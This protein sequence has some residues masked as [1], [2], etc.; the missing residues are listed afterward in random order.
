[1]ELTFKDFKE[2]IWI[3]VD[4]HKNFWTQSTPIYKKIVGKL[5]QKNYYLQRRNNL[6]FPIL[7]F[8]VA[9]WIKI[10]FKH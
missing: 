4:L 9:R 3:L 7:S 5:T 10:D 1:M 2:K 6:S 8:F